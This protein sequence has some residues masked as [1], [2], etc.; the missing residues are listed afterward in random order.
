MNLE[1]AHTDA[2]LRSAELIHRTSLNETFHE[3]IELK[4]GSEADKYLRVAEDVFRSQETRF[5]DVHLFAPPGQAEEGLLSNV[6]AALRHYALKG[7]TPTSPARV[8]PSK[9]RLDAD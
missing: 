3:V 1:T 9:S 7:K 8:S 6:R 4:G 2:R 5:E